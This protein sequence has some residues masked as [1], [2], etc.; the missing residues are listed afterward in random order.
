L[1]RGFVAYCCAWV[2]VPPVSVELPVPAT[3][4]VKPL[5]T[6]A[7]GSGKILVFQAARRSFA[8]G[9]SRPSNTAA[10]TTATR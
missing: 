2:P 5:V 1:R 10:R 8:S 9:L 4:D 3:M 6:L 7:P